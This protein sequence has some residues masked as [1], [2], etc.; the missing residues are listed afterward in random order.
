MVSL[1]V[2]GYATRRRSPA[3]PSRQRVFPR[4]RRSRCRSCWA[5][6]SRPRH[7]PA[8]PRWPK[9]AEID[10]NNNNRTTGQQQRNLSVSRRG[11]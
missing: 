8:V 7:P 6:G 9:V 11:C 5:P 1:L 2:R 4:Q 3:A 10:I